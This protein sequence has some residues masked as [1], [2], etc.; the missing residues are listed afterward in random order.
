M[1]TW[2]KRILNKIKE[3]IKRRERIKKIKKKDPYVYK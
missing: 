3:D 2:I 1:I